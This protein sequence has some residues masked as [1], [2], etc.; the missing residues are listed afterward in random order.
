MSD[1]IKEL[2]AKSQSYDTLLLKTKGYGYDSLCLR[3][4]IAREAQMQ[5]ELM[6]DKR[7]TGGMKQDAIRAR[8]N[9]DEMRFYEILNELLGEHD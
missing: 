5:L 1:R 8:A 9:R 7:V 3:Y 6:E 2:I 4:K